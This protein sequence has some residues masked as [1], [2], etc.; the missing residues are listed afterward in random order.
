MA[1]E[2]TL[3]GFR[4]KHVSWLTIV[5]ALLAIGTFLAISRPG[6]QYAVPMGI[7]GGMME[8]GEGYTTSVP[9]GVPDMPSL[10]GM[11]GTPTGT[12]VVYP[13]PYS[14]IPPP[15]PI[16]TAYWIPG[17]EIA[18]KVPI[19]KSASTIVSQ[20]TCFGRKPRRVDSSA[21]PRYYHTDVEIFMYGYRRFCI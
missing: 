11:S 2:S 17:R 20:E 9:V 7:G 5:L 3:R 4:P 8:Y 16:G 15:I 1:D 18:K 13:S 6:I 10:I 14:I 21:I 19:A 12:D